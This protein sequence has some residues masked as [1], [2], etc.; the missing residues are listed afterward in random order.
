MFATVETHAP[1]SPCGS[2]ALFAS[3]RYAEIFGISCA[4]VVAEGVAVGSRKHEPR[5]NDVA[6]IR[7]QAKKRFK[8]IDP[9]G[10]RIYFGAYGMIFFQLP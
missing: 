6:R 1:Q 4:P 10:R 8:K 9:F 3:G 2:T 5:Q 7:T